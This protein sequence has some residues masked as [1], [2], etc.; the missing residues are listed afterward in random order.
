MQNPGVVLAKQTGFLRSDIN[1]EHFVSN[2]NEKK[3]NEIKEKKR[4]ERVLTMPSIW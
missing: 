4:K 1:S 2:N 3:R